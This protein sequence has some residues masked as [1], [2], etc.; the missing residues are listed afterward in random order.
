MINYSLKQESFIEKYFRLGS[1]SPKGWR[2]NLSSCPYC[3]DGRS[4]NSRSHFLFR[5][6][7][8]GWQCFNCG[9]KH[10]FSGSN[11][12]TLAT[13]IS[14]SAWK[15][16]GALL[17]EIKQEKIFPNS[18]LKDQEEVKD[19]VDSN[20]LELIDY[21]EIELPDVSIKLNTKS[22]KISPSYRKK[23]IDNKL[24]A[25]KYLIDRGLESKINYKDLYIC[26]DG[27]YAN[28]L[29]F[30]IYFDGKLISWAAR[31]L[32]PTKTKYLYPPS[33]D[34]FNDRGRI[35]YGLDKIFKSHDVKQIF[36]TE[37]INDAIHLN[38]IAVLSKNMTKEQI[39][40]LKEFNFQKKK[41][42]FVLDNDT[43]TRWDTDL[44][45]GELG[46]IVIKEHQDN[47]FVSLPNFGY[48]VKDVSESM[49]KNGFL[50]T[51]DTIISSFVSDS[52][53]ISM[54]MKLKSCMP[55]KVK[56]YN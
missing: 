37:S 7:E 29:I 21:K 25:E 50:E 10:R 13:F 41:L 5:N 30:P 34:E 31:A 26:M 49:V 20:V 23:F 28:R 53:N 2:Q 18:S 33:S 16:T 47:W 43:L 1:L 44:K 22:E 51:Y 14:K 45:G 36:V 12:S 11:I 46:K 38:G 48:G 15:K 56:K 19:E 55:K 35:I 32:F 6:D 8:I 24:K 3:H 40:I 42:V 52:A 54:K 17:L 4:K 9:G 27:D 39:N